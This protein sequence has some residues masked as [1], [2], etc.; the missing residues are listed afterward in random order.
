MNKSKRQKIDETFQLL[1]AARNEPLTTA[2][3]NYLEKVG[4]HKGVK[5]VLIFH[6]TP[7][8]AELRKGL[9]GKLSDVTFLIFESA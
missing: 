8:D 6:D 4:Y 5:T 7:E 1:E 2:E 9:E 3:K